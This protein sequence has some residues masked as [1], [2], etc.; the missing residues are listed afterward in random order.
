MQF[1]CI[2]YG[3]GSIRSKIRL[4]NVRGDEITDKGNNALNES[5]PYSIV[6]G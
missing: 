1:N 3:M 5:I 4:D 2:S 6:M